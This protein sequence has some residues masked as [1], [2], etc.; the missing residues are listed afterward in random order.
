MI[1]FIYKKEQE[2]AAK[3]QKISTH[4]L[5]EMKGIER[6]LLGELAAALTVPF[7]QM[8]EYIIGKLA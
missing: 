8:K 2:R 1:H 4:Y 5:E 6:L 3:G 7:P